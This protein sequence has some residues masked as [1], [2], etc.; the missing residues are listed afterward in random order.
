MSG[1][2]V[3]TDLQTRP[4]RPAFNTEGETKEHEVLQTR[5]RRPLANVL[6]GTKDHEGLETKPRRPPVSVM[7]MVNKFNSHEGLSSSSD[8]TTP[9]NTQNRLSRSASFGEI[10]TSS[11]FGD[12]W[13]KLDHAEAAEAPPTV[14]PPMPT[15]TRVPLKPPARRKK[16]T[17]ATE[18]VV[19]TQASKA[20][21]TPP[22]VNTVLTSTVKVNGAPE[23]HRAPPRPPPPNLKPTRRLSPRLV[24]KDPSHSSHEST[25][26][27]LTGDANT[28]SN[29]LRRS[30]TY[31]ES[32]SLTD[33]CEESSQ[34]KS[35]GASLLPHSP[36]VQ[37][38]IDPDPSYCF[39]LGRCIISD[40]SFCFHLGEFLPY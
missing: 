16:F 7:A 20:P 17:D 10:S 18:P 30:S 11:T 22:R 32:S 39:K 15:G 37:H 4:R 8:I 33:S 2:N 9:T 25:V 3:R 12:D 28:T 13:I 27:N 34:S 14:A 40:S 36:G 1:T 35:P 38:S 31:S 26:S 29:S 6:M 24:Q 23:N 5:P 19:A 21:I